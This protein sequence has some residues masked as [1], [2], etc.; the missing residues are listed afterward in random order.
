[1]KFFL[2]TNFIIDQG[3]SC[4]ISDLIKENIYNTKC[5]ALI[6]DQILDGQPYFEKVLKNLKINFPKIDIQV[7]DKQGEPTYR[8]LNKLANSFR[9]KDIDVVIATI[10]MF[11]EVRD[12]NRQNIEN[13]IIQ[14]ECI[15]IRI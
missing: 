3:S 4:K 14:E 12:W 9:K 2:N 11:H 6:Y 7:N 10:S 13:L 15:L 1:M 8:Y 5:P